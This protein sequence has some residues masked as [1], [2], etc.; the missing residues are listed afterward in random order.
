MVYKQVSCR[1]IL[2]KVYRDFRVKDSSALLD[3][4]IEWIGEAIEIIGCG[5]SYV[6]DNADSH[7]TDYR[8]ILPCPVECLLGI[9]YKGKRLLLN[10]GL[11]IKNLV[12][13][14]VLQTFPE[15]KEYCCAPSCS[16]N[17]YQ[18]NGKCIITSFK[19]GDIK[20]YYEKI[21]VDDDG[22]PCVPDDAEVKNAISW[23]VM[24]GLLG[25]GYTHP[26]FDWK[27]TDALW[28]K[29]YPRAQNRI[30]MPN[31]D[32]YSK[33]KDHMVSLLPYISREDSLFGQ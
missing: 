6:R 1:T 19:E 5:G 15:M 23:Y 25:A 10:D 17:F 13:D 28:E 33:F 14:S 26:V 30:K 18:L 12:K 22:F 7:V 9:T 32:R 8:T 20:I 21:S 11:R 2:A 24:R 3:D 4:S 29:H 16:T 27:T 31:R